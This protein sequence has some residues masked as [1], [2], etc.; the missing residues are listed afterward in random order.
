MSNAKLFVSMFSTAL[1]TLLVTQ[2][3]HA[4][5]GSAKAL[6]GMWCS[7]DAG[8]GETIVQYS[9]TDSEVTAF[10][11]LSEADPRRIGNQASINLT[12]EAPNVFVRRA[13]VGA[14]EEFSVQN[15]QL[16]VNSLWIS[17]RGT[18]KETRQVLATQR[19]YKCDVGQALRRAQAF[20]SSPKAEEATRMALLREEQFELETTRNASKDAYYAGLIRQLRLS[21]RL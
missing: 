15:G 9:A 7:Q 18:G 19:F 1:M 21:P 20:M 16:T 5:S 3:A 2:A 11:V 10:T 13:L 6:E 12:P 4:T 14:D 8:A 17:N